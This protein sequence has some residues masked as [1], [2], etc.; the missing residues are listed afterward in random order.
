M[1]IDDFSVAAGQYGDLKA[2]LA[3]ATT[4]A[5]HRGVVLS[6]I[7]SVEHQPV[8]VPRLNICLWLR[9]HFFTSLDAMLNASAALRS[10]ISLER[11]MLHLKIGRK[12]FHS[13]TEANGSETDCLMCTGAAPFRRSLRFSRG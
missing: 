1:P 3:N 13:S 7:A 11:C 6:R 10:G 12:E 2:E 4:H 5:I 9:Q 8:N